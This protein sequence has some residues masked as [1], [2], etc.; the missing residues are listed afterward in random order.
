M[1]RYMF[2]WLASFGAGL[3]A[4]R[5]GATAKCSERL[6]LHF[7]VESVTM[8]SPEVPLGRR[9]RLLPSLRTQV[10]PAMNQ[11]RPSVGALLMTL[12]LHLTG[13][14][15]ESGDAYDRSLTF[16]RDVR[17]ILKAM[18]FHCHGE[19]PEVSGQLDLRLVRL[20]QA[21]G[22][23]GAAIAVGDAAQS[24]LW[25]KVEADE[26]PPG[27]KKLSAEQKEKVRRWIDEGAKTARPEPA[28]V[29]EARFS[30]EEREHW[31]FR[32]VVRPELPMPTGYELANAVDHFIA[33][34]LSQMELSFSPTATRRTLIRRLAIDLTGLPP[35]PAEVEA[36]ERDASPDAYER[37]VDRLLASPQFGVRWGR[38]WLDVV[39]YAESNGGPESDVERPYAWRYRDYVV[40]AFNSSKPY[41]HFVR[42]QLAGDEMLTGAVDAY[43]TRQLELLT[44]TGFLRMGP[45]PTQANN[46]LENRNLAVAESVKI[47]SSALVG[48]TIGCAQCHDHKYDPIGMD[49]YYRFRAIFDPVFPL[50]Q[51]QTPNERLVDM[52]TKE[53]QAIVD[54]IETRAKTLE[55][56]LNRR[57]NEVC[58]KI[59]DRKLADVPESERESVRAAV[60]APDDQKTAEQRVLL[61]RYPMVKPLGTI[62]GLLVEYDAPSYRAFEKELAAIAEVRAAKPDLRMIMATR[63]RDGVVPVSAV[64]FRGDPES[65]GDAVKPGELAILQA[66]RIPEFPE[67]DPTLPGT[68]RRSAFARYLTDGRHPLLARV[69]V[70]RVWHYHMGRGLVATPG[71]FGLSGER[72]THPELLD[73]LTDDFVEHGWDQKRLHRMIVLSTTYRQT[74]RR[75]PELDARDPENRW[76]ARMNVRRLEAEVIRDSLLAVSGTLRLELGGASLPVTE[77]R[78]G[79]AVI[80]KQKFRDGLLAGVDSA[81]QQGSRRSVYVQVRRALPLNMLATFDQPAMLPNCSQRPVSTVATQALWFLNDTTSVESA[82]QMARRLVAEEREA[83]ARID[84]LFALLF[85][86]RPTAQERSSCEAFLRDQTTTLQAETDDEWQK[87]KAADPNAVEHRAW[88]TLCQT[89]M[90]SN[91]FLYRP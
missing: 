36:F 16:E 27:E 43:N 90:A 72:P 50:Q 61:D 78:E 84:R 45:D 89:L 44:A 86:E 10:D 19:Q 1:R 41:D 74:T 29:R 46:T 8:S 9:S 49:D 63:E 68:G 73:W 2:A 54:E 22:E 18:C 13:A 17:P 81:A 53:V 57:R 26:M 83:V 79:K 32:P 37:L 23:S 7:R 15:A 42:E 76:W 4:W 12:V 88:A 40:D 85:S 14:A 28:D 77:D 25:H 67:D 39:G 69:F 91:R 6:M 48:L 71:D 80:G 60:L 47:I 64:F 3:F 5:L 11:V 31:A 21:G 55:D 20:M 24:L 34:K 66:D 65:P 58:Q 30:Q 35:T 38:H 51:W 82:E 52:T 87:V 33:D 70:N 62:L 59:Q 56:D 75:T